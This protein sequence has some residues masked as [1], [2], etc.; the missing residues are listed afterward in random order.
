MASET[1][2]PN[3]MDPMDPALEESLGPG[4]FPGHDPDLLA[5]LRVSAGLPPASSAH[6]D[7]PAEVAKRVSDLEIT[8]ASLL[9]RVDFLRDRLAETG[10]EVAELGKLNEATPDP[11][12]D[13]PKRYKGRDKGAA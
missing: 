12:A 8:V 7:E 5:A 2:D 3:L 10:R 13:P 6:R 1:L 11:L 9:K 4:S